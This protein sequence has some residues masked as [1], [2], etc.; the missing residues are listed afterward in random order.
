LLNIQIRNS[1][2]IRKFAVFS[3]ESPTSL[4]FWNKVSN[5]ILNNRKIA[6]RHCLGYRP[7]GLFSSQ[8]QPLTNSQKFPE[9]DPAFQRYGFRNVTVET[10]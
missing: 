9:S 1:G 7:D 6:F 4:M 10:D 3:T 5:L 2:E 8:L